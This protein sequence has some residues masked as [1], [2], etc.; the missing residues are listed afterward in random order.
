MNTSRLYPQRFYAPEGQGGTPAAETP[1][2]TQATDD[3]EDYQE[4][5]VVVE[6]APGEE[7][8][9]GGETPAAAAAPVPK[10]RGPKRYAE[11]NRR[12]QEATSYAQRVEEENK[13]LRE[14]A[15][16]AEADAAESNTVAMNTYAAK[17]ESDLVS[18]RREYAEA[19][20]SDD[21]EK[22][23]A[24]TEALASAKQSK[25]DVDR[26][27]RTEK[28][29]AAP[30][31]TAP[32][33]PQ[34]FQDAPAHIR[35]WMM[36]NRYFDHVGRDERGNPIVDSTGKPAG[37][38]DFD[39]DMHAEAVMFATKLERQIARGQ[40]TIQKGSKEY[41]QAINEHV[42]QEFP[43]YFDDDEAAPARPART[44]GKGSPVAAPG[45]RSTPGTTPKGGS[46]TMKLSADEIRFITR[47]HTNGG[48]PKY[49]KGHPQ[50]FKPMSLPDAKVSYARRKMTQAKENP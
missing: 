24:A 35:D 48:G 8:A 38:P 32:A 45:N 37:N 39:P 44:P 23:T 28:P 11:L 20:K 46:Q 19:L 5:E 13:L 47:S 10:K 4:E 29:A 31:A 14:R 42:Q 40:S 33:A 1:A 30:A 26:F 2:S 34:P 9:E 16:K 43:D 7:P 17:A 6:D 3:D 18:A 22:I 12:A 41:F 50:E 27:K 21:A 36:E 25:D 49:P 15:T